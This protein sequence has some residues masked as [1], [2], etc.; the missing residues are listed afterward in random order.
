M[1]S[2]GRYICFEGLDFSGKSTLIRELV[3]RHPGVVSIREPG[4]T[5][6]AEAMRAEMMKSGGLTNLTF[7]LTMMA[8]R[9]DLFEKKIRPTLK[10]GEHIFSDRCL[11]SSWA[12]QVSEDSTLIPVFTSCVERLLHGDGLV[13]KPV[14]IFLDLSPDTAIE[15][16]KLFTNEREV[17]HFDE[18]GIITFE[19][20]RRA[21]LE[22]LH[23][24][25][26][27]QG[28]VIDA[29]CSKGEVLDSVL[30]IVE[31]MLR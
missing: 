30:A 5:S 7:L 23:E 19:K 28:Y 1:S 6:F 13:I 3:S 26:K 18:A 9:S 22:F 16:L 12:Y 10:N 2:V 20:R 24:L 14:Y 29:N 25:P 8:A 21:Y 4:G 31:P 17:N 15:R 27:G 11:L